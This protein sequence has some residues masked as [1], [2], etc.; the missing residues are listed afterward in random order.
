MSPYF[1]MYDV[2]GNGWIDIVEMTKIVKS[3]YCMMGPQ[4]QS[5]ERRAKEIFRRMDRNADGRVTK[6]E[7][8]QTC[9][10]IVIICAKHSKDFLK[11]FMFSVD[12]KLC[13]MLN[14]QPMQLFCE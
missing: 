6:D 1:R 3:I 5:A 7:F 2:D 13:E 4:S 11:I 14:P 8:V 12:P 10:G 9:L